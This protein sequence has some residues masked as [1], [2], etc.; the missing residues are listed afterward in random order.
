[1]KSF[2]PLI[3]ILLV[4]VT[5]VGTFLYMTRARTDVPSPATGNPSG[6]S[7]SPTANQ[8]V[9]GVPGAEPPHAIGPADAP[10]TIEEFGDFE[11]PPCGLLHP[12]VKSMVKEFGPRLRVVFREYPLP[13]H[14]HALNAARAAEAAGLQ[15]KFWEMHGMLYDNQ[16][17]WHEA[18]DARP[19]FE[20]YAQAIGLDMARYRRDLGSKTVENRIYLD[21]NRAHSLGVRATPTV[22]L[23]G[24]EVPFEQLAPEKLRVL[25][26]REIA[27]SNK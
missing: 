16:K 2:L 23:N 14:S 19:I 13:N 6:A 21:G 3:L 18:F 11:C 24:R 8:V 4:L 27:Q 15:G 12:V 5:G 9:T 1:M 20:K 22:F 25:I 26:A 7:A 17:A 10:A